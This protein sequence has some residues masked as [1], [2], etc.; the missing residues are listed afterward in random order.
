MS[1][2]RLG[3]YIQQVNVRNT[4]LEV[5]TLLGVSITKKLIPSIANTIGTD[6]SVYKIIERQQ[7]AYGTVTSRNGDK[8]SIALADEHDQA[9]V[10]QI[11]VVFEVIDK[12]ELLPEYLMMWFS[13]P[14]FD[15]YA[16]YHSHG[17]TR[18]T[19]DWDDMCEVQLPI[20]SIDKQRA[21]VAE[22]QS[23]ENKIAINNQICEKLEATAQALYRHW[24]VD[25]EF[26]DEEGKPYKSSGGAMVY[27]DELEKEIPEGWEVKELGEIV[28]YKKGYAFKSEDYT[29]IGKSIIRVSDL[30][31]RYINDSEFYRISKKDIYESFSVQYRDLI[32][33]TVGSW[34]TNPFSVVG[35]VVRTPSFADGY[36]LNQNMVRLRFQDIINELVYQQLITKNFSEY[37]ISSAQ[38]SANQASITLEHIFKFKVLIPDII[39]LNSILG[40]FYSFIDQVILQNR[41]LTHLQSLLLSRLAKQAN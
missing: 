3:D 31:S 41:N 18:E 30:G 1:Y 11:Y 34:P 5:D 27:N 25:F 40:G 26:P 8:I 7:F 29:E 23:I 15:R 13:R 19:F 35:K 28:D 16:R 33:T 32:V 22:Y 39:V 36:Y 4:A 21:I 38:G 10:S 37:L 24:F 20:P 14:E 2:K 12:D 9:L 6:M 17:S